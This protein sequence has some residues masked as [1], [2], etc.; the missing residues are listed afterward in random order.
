MG[1]R[2]YKYF[3]V[4]INSLTLFVILG[5]A[6]G[7]A[8]IVLNRD[9]P[10]NIIVEYPEQA[11]VSVCVCV[12]VCACVCVCVRAHIVCVCA[13]CMRVRVSVRVLCVCMCMCLSV[14]ARWVGPKQRLHVAPA[15]PD[16]PQLS[17]TAM[18][19]VCADGGGTACACP[20]QWTRRVPRGAGQLW[21][22]H[23]RA[24]KPHHLHHGNHN[25]V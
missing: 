6:W 25:V 3:Y 5:Y 11:Y 24:C 18:C 7:I 22:D 16:P 15:Q 19:Q 4:F 10:I 17:L 8:S 21:E 23:K 20:G 13:V 9:Q 14:C 1:K 12:C 2:N